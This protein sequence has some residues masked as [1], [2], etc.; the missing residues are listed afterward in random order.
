LP[1]A[2]SVKDLPGGQT[3]LLSVHQVRNIA[4][5]PNESDEDGA[6]EII[7]DTKSWL[8][9]NG[10]LNNPEIGDDNS[11]EDNESDIDLNNGP[12]AP[13]SPGHLD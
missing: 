11:G 13:D 1:P 2:L 8:D 5:H 7:S 4:N 3:Q 9:W 10:D 6:A 12:E